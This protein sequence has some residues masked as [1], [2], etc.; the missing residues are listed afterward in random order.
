MAIRRRPG[1]RTVGAYEA[2]THLPRLLAE[3]EQGARITITRNGLA[4]AILS[5]AGPAAEAQPLSQVVQ[6]LR[7]GRRGVRL[8]GM[9]IAALKGTGRR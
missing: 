2:K 3:V 7:A 9:S 1:H 6:E 5:P 4:V 8:R